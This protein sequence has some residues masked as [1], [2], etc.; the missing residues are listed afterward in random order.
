MASLR[1]IDR[2]DLEMLH[3]IL[4][5][6]DDEDIIASADVADYLGVKAKNGR[7]P[8]GRVSTRLAYMARIGQL[9]RL[10]PRLW[11]RHRK[12]AIWRITDF[13]Y[14]LLNGKLPQA[15]ETQI[16][17][18]TAGK[19]V[20]MMQRLSQRLASTDEATALR[21]QWQHDEARRKGVV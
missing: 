2:T 6:K 21:R 20:L 17:N 7:S 12:E 11:G 18:G 19:R 9:E 15:V 3:I 4:D 16:Q 14:E 13:G 8:A 1:N 5:C 10:D